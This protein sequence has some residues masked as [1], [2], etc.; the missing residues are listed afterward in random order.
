[1]YL[2]ISLFVSIEAYD[3]LAAEAD[4]RPD[5]HELTDRHRKG[6]SR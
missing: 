3:C 6:R 5:W 4:L 1:M 2:F